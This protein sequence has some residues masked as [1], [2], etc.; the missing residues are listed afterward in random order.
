MRGNL[1][2]SLTLIFGSEGGYVNRK[3]DRGGATKYGITIGTLSKHRGHQCSIADVMNLKLAEAVQIY[4]T[5]FWPQV[6]GDIAPSGLDYMLLDAGIMS[7]PVRAVQWLQDVLKDAGVYTGKRDGW[8]GTGTAAGVRDFPGGIEELL[9]R[10]AKRRL[11]YYRQ[12]KEPGGWK[13]NGRGWERRVTGIDPKGL[14]APEPGVLGNAL[15]IAKQDA[16][17]SK[18]VGLQTPSTP[19]VTPEPTVSAAEVA[20]KPEVLGLAGTI[21]AAFTAMAGGTPILQYTAAGLAIV[22][23]GIAAVYIVR[24]IL[25]DND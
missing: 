8:Y 23:G 2:E 10:Y 19:T 24:R 20:Q 15:R 21:M 9:H 17:I 11:D 16:S 5:S 6:G 18:V 13:S 7:G 4:Q 14:L 3:D 1:K 12:I 22:F 25:R